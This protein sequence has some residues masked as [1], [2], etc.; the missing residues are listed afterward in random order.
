MTK[1]PQYVPPE[2]DIEKAIRKAA[3]RGR[4]RIKG[5]EE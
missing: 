3:D 4:R 1:K 5:L 2:S